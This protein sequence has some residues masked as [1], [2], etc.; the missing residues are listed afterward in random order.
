MIA[1]DAPQQGLNE[2][3]DRRI[4]YLGKNIILVG[5]AMPTLP[6]GNAIA[7]RFWFKRLLQLMQQV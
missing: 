7:A 2:F 6:T 5:W 4:K 1:I 3:G